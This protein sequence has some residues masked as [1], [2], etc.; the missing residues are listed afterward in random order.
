MC[1]NPRILFV[2]NFYEL[3]SWIITTIIKHGI[4]KSSYAVFY[5]NKDIRNLYIPT[6]IYFIFMINNRNYRSII[7]RFHYIIKAWIA[8]FYE[9]FCL[10]KIK[11]FL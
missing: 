3:I 5:I 8:C 9:N 10:Y 1:L 4:D 11:K 6:S 7:P 2:R